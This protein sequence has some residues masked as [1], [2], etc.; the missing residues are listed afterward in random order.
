MS[1]S[2]AIFY[3]LAAAG[4]GILSLCFFVS[5]LLSSYKYGSLKGLLLCLF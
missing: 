5:A 4:L 1:K 3:L 2:I